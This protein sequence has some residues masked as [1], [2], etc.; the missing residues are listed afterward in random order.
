MKHLFQ[1]LGMGEPWKG[2]DVKNKP[3]GGHKINL[4][5]DELKN[6]KD[7]SNL[8]RGSIDFS[9]KHNINILNEY[10]YRLSCSRTAT[11][12]FCWQTKMRYLI[13]SFRSGPTSFL[14][15]KI[16]AGQVEKPTL[17]STFQLKHYFISTFS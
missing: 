15:L 1:V 3:G 8:V 17:K 14:G 9:E 16:S 7:A 2:G 10:Y 5:K 11:M 6:H 13:S 4:L 12:C